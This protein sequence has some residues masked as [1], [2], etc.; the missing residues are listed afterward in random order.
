MS[1]MRAHPLH[2]PL[3]RRRLLTVV[4][5]GLDADA[6]DLTGIPAGEAYVLQM[7]YDDSAFQTPEVSSPASGSLYLVTLNESGGRDATGVK[8][9][10]WVNAVDLGVGANQTL[11]PGLYG[12]GTGNNVV[13]PVVPPV[14]PRPLVIRG[15]GA[16]NR[17]RV[18]R[19]GNEIRYTIDGQ[20]FRRP[21]S[22]VSSITVLAGAGDDAVLIEA[23][24][25]SVVLA[26]AGDDTVAG[27]SGDD[28]LDGGAGDDILLGG[29]G[30]DRLFGRAG[31]DDLDGGAGKNVMVGGAGNDDLLGHGKLVDR[32]P[33]DRRLNGTP[34]PT[35]RDGFSFTWDSGSGNW[36]ISW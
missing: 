7:S 6:V 29:W 22:D 17:I 11:Y 21:A 25:P 23:D 8:D 18:G 1:F 36:L 31:D 16:A 15:T 30:K 14:A 3:E 26:G 2:E 32:S 12:V 28:H 24:L 35:A 9:G 10:Q 4:H 5:A 20:T 34:A 13:W 33:A 19:E 27:G